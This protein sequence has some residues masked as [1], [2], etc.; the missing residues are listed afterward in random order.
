M[1]EDKLMFDTNIVFMQTGAPKLP[2]N[3]GAN[4]PENSPKLTARKDI[5][6]EIHRPFTRETILRLIQVIKE[7]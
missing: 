6:D 3:P 1:R 5:L 4:Q 7:I 2:K